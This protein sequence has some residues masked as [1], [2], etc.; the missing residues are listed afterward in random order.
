MNVG[1]ILRQAARSWPDR[2]GVVDVGHEGE[3]RRE[4]RFAELDAQACKVAGVLAGHGLGPGERVALIGENSAEFVAGWFG[5]VYAGCAVVPI[6]TLSAPPELRYRIE[7]A[8]CRALLCD[9]ARAASL[10]QNSGEKALAVQCLELADVLASGQ[11]GVTYAAD[12]SPDDPALIL[13][14]SGTS[15]HAKGAA[16]SHASLLMH[17]A[18]LSHHTLQL[19]EA[20]RVLGVLPLSHSFGC[21]MA[22]LVS[23]FAGARCVLVPRFDAARTLALLHREAITWLPAVPTMFAAWAAEPEPTTP[24]P[25]LLRWALSAGAPL[26]DETARRAE[27]RLGVEI[28][29]GYGMTEATFCTI[30]APPDER[31][32]GSVG[33]PVWGVEVRLLDEAGGDVPAGESGEVAVRGHNAMSGYLHDP[34][35]TAHIAREGFIRSGDVGRLDGQG[36]LAIVDRI[37]DLI[38]R[39]GHNVYPS[40]VETALATHADVAEVAVIGRPDDYYGEEVVAVVVKREG[41]ELSEAQLLHWARSQFGPNKRPREVAFVDALPLGPS[42]KVLKRTLRQW[43]LEGRL[44]VLSRGGE[45]TEPGR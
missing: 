2:V 26:A 37:K 4:L 3:P 7:H 1:Q 25:S 22:M 16:I 18:L 32:F 44:D 10:R 40:E 29:Q 5:I 20:D 12:V 36:R 30:N 38:I 21:R 35:A 19:T 23:V 31:V 15:G 17:S 41:A 24:E 6:P 39:G 42:G 14:T 8:N 11:P 34:E 33:R 43:L 13:Y 28:R 27:R 9:A 45:P